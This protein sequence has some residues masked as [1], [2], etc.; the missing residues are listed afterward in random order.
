ML[1]VPITESWPE[2]TQRVIALV[3]NGLTWIEGNSQRKVKVTDWQGASGGSALYPA[4]PGAQDRRTWL[5]GAALSITVHW[6]IQV[7]EDLL[8]DKSCILVHRLCPFLA[9]KESCLTVAFSYIYIIILCSYCSLPLTPTTFSC[10]MSHL[11][12]RVS[13]GTSFKSH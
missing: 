12:P 6:I 3:P 5:K 9:Y 10:P 8:S 11:L 4:G 1:W 2:G 13:S 7:L